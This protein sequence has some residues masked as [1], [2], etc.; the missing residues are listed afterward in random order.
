MSEHKIKGTCQ[1]NPQA[2]AV[3]IRGNK[4]QLEAH[5]VNQQLPVIQVAKMH[6]GV[7]LITYQAI[8][9]LV[10]FSSRKGK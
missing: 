8:S 10:T 1:R 7:K 3:T 2:C 6:T 4:K 9:T 5:D